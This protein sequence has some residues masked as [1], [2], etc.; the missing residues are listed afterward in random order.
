MHWNSCIESNSKMVN[1]NTSMKSIGYRLNFIFL[2]NI[3][4]M[5][6]TKKMGRQNT[7]KYNY[8]QSW[9]KQS[10]LL[11]KKCAHR[12]IITKPIEKM[13]NLLCDKL[14]GF[15][16]YS[17]VV[18][19]LNNFEYILMIL[20]DRFRIIYTN[21]NRGIELNPNTVFSPLKVW[22]FQQISIS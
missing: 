13:K 10:K 18:P 15:S 11:V 21:V 8:I 22:Y 16:H 7:W 2:A 17:P 9:T 19:I 12:A 5:N 6:R 3:H 4:Y 20:S 1:K 14:N